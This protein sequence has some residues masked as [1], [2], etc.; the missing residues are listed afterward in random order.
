MTPANIAGMAALNGLQIV[1]LTDHNT[2]ANCPPFFAH[3]KR[4]GLI[5]VGGM[6][7]TTA[8]DI[9]AV[10][11]FPD[12]D[13]TMS[14][15]TFVA[16]RRCKIPN[17]VDI[18]GNQFLMNEEDEVCG[19][20]P[21]LLIPATA[22]SL[23]EAHAEVTKR[24]GVLYPAH[25]DRTSN[26]ILAILGELPPAPVF[27]AYE[28]HDKESAERLTKKHTDLS[29]L[30]RTV[31]SDAHHLWDIAEAKFALSLPDEPYSSDRVRRALISRLRGES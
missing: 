1:A 25:I 10:C 22:L 13:G 19:T 29:D 15:D 23:T 5:P 7:L 11:L 28:L 20:I 12:L 3:A 30:V 16:G 26:G 17:R 4:L 9:H 6:E 31:S 2:A 18:F 14:F 21:E 24:G 27:T 8:E